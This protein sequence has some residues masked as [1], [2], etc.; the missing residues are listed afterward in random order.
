MVASGELI[1]DP[2]EEGVPILRRGDTTHV[3]GDDV[4]ADVTCAPVSEDV[5]AMQE[6]QFQPQAQQTPSQL[7]LEDA[8][9]AKL[10]YVKATRIVQERMQ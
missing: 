3:T 10:A 7:A 4:M 1:V 9:L 5:S 6:S 2:I 8:R